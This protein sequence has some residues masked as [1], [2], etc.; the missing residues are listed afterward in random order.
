MA[1]SLFN[2][3][4]LFFITRVERGK[5]HMTFTES[6]RYDSGHRMSCH[7]ESQSQSQHVTKKSADGYEDC[8]R[9]DA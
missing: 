9:Q 5:Y 2:I 7:M 6:Q 3:S 1:K 4:F 8:G